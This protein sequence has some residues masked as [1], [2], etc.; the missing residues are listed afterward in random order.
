MLEKK[1]SELTKLAKNFSYKAAVQKTR[2]KDM[3]T[4]NP[5]TEDLFKRMLEV[6]QKKRIRFSDIR[7]H[8][9][10]KKYFKE[11]AGDSKILYSKNLNI[12]SQIKKN[13]N[14]TGL[15]QDPSIPPSTRIFQKTS[16]TGNFK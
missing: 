13:K 14:R 2:A 6:D 10:F 12:A 3:S 4:C 1:C 15:R 11:G 16:Y 7:E 5:D 8:A 9:V